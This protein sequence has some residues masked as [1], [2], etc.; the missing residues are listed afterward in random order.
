MD[1]LAMYF[2]ELASKAAT[3]LGYRDIRVW[4]NAVYRPMVSPEITKDQ[5]KPQI[6]SSNRTI[7]IQ[8]PDYS[9]IFFIMTKPLVGGMDITCTIHGRVNNGVI[10]RLLDVWDNADLTSAYTKAEQQDPM[11]RQPVKAKTQ[12]KSKLSPSQVEV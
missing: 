5:V 3:E 12:T 11:Y 7:L 9:V 6:Q 2:Q 10:D 4:E 1:D 8:Q